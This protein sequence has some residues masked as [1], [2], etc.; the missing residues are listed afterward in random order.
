MTRFLSFCALLALTSTLQAQPSATNAPKE[1]DFPA[2][3]V[4]TDKEKKQ[5]ERTVKQQTRKARRKIASSTAL[6]T[7]RYYIDARGT[8]TYIE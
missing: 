8:K 4:K 7:R 5:E 6:K 2:S 3:E 1:K